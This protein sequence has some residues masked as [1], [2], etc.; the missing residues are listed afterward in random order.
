MFIDP[1]RFESASFL[2]C[3][4][5]NCY[6]LDGQDAVDAFCD[7]RGDKG[8]D[9]IY[10]NSSDETIVILQTTIS[11]K[12]NS[13]SDDRSLR[14]FA[15]ISIGFKSPSRGCPRNGRTGHHRGCWGGSTSS[16]LKPE[17]LRAVCLRWI[18]WHPFSRRRS[19]L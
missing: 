19:R 17:G 9:G 6:R 5:E 12:A 10:V 2:I 18:V 11:Q 1:K 14:E 7:Q 13:T 4:L 16:H 8:V 3:Y 15:G